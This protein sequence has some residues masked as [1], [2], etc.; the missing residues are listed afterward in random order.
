MIPYYFA[1]NH[2]NYARYG[3]YYLRSIEKLLPGVLS[4]FLKGQHVTRHICGVWNGLWS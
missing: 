2:V 3:L 1:A 4:L